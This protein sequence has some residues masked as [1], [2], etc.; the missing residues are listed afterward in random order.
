GDPLRKIKVTRRCLRALDMWKRPW[1]LCLPHGLGSGH[2]PGQ[3]PSWY[4]SGVFA[5]PFFR[6]ANSLHPEGV[7]GG[8]ICLPLPS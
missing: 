2:E 3:L 4:S 7:R 8:Y 5:G 1:F 6:G